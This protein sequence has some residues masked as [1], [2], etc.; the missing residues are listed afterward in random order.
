[1]KKRDV[2]EWN[3]RTRVGQLVKEGYI[4]SINELFQNVLNI[5]ETE[6]ID[7]LLPRLQEEVLDINLVQKQTDAGEKS[8]FK[9]LVAVGCEGFLGI[10]ESKNPE[11][12]PAIRS[13]I[14]H[15]KLNISPIRRGCGSSEC[16]CGGLHSLPFN[17]SGKCGSVS[18]YLKPAPRG[19]GIVAAKTVKTILKLAKIEDV[20]SRT[21][22]HTKTAVNF[23][24]ATFRAL[25]NTYSIIS[26]L[27]DWERRE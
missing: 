27:W 14:S 4:T 7:I 12:G 9:A 15:A 20:W 3:P 19:L 1:M 23:A 25:K 26:P 17:V 2:D 21:K 8:R 5:R 16:R 22:G 10:G 6:I 18:V 13:A 11:I 24:K